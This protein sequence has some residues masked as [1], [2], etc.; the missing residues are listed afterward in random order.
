M[1]KDRIISRP[2]LSLLRSHPVEERGADEVPECNSG[3]SL[4]VRC[5]NAI[6]GQVH[7]LVFGFGVY[8][9]LR[10]TYPPYRPATSS[11]TNLL[12]RH[13]QRHT[14][15]STVPEEIMFDLRDPEEIMAS[16]S[17]WKRG[18]PEYCGPHVID[19]H[20]FW[21]KFDTHTY[22]SKD[23]DFD[24]K[25][26]AMKASPFVVSLVSV[27]GGK[28]LFMGSGTIVDC[29]EAIGTHLS[30]STILTSASLFRTSAGSDALPDDIEV[31]VYLSDGTLLNGEVYACDFH[32]NLALIK[33]ESDAML[34]P[35]NLRNLDD[36][37]SIHPCE[38]QNGAGSKS[39]RL[40]PHSDLFHLSPGDEVVAL[41]RYFLEPHEIMAAP[42][43]FSLDSVEFDCKELFRANCKI[44]KCGIGGPL[45]NRYGDVIGVNFYD[46]L[47]TP[48]LPINIALKWL[49]HFKKNRRFCRRWLGMQMTNLFAARL[50]QLEKIIQKF[51]NIS[52]GVFVEEVIKGSPAERAGILYGDVIVRCAGNNVGSFL[53]FCGI[54]WDKTGKSVKLVVI[55]ATSGVRLKL[56]L[57]LDETSPDKF[58]RWPLPEECRMS[59]KRIRMGKEKRSC[60]ST[61]SAKVQDLAKLHSH[62]GALR[63]SECGSSAKTAIS[64]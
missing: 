4:G 33:I 20:S 43:K 3:T 51:P 26:A 36:S 27:S 60:Y 44:S 55:R 48:F 18:H 7:S 30:T 10:S 23:L 49:E 46:R 32:Y 1:N 13:G 14:A 63:V 39:F 47:C 25:R 53:E 2:R 57:K 8:I 22:A 62:S 50:G 41:G 28:A 54:I 15:R 59:V 29:E 40:H 17:P 31:E 12:N 16:F 52:R 11:F 61:V 35:A 42:G 34:Q 6:Y 64:E 56:K 24:T 58:Y 45:I 5:L 19:Q 21:E 37:I 38:I 9:S